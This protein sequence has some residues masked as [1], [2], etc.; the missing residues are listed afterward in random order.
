MVVLLI[1]SV[2]VFVSNMKTVQIYGGV[3][4]KLFAKATESNFL[5]SFE[6]RVLVS[7]LIITFL[8]SAWKLNSRT[9]QIWGGLSLFFV[10]FFC[11]NISYGKLFRFLY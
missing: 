2:T 5:C 10:L 4:Y 7:H 8:N 9:G 6:R 1:L 3:I 11:F